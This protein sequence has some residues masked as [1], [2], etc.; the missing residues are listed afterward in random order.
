MQSLHSRVRND[1]PGFGVQWDESAWSQLQGT[2]VHVWTRTSTRT[3][4]SGRRFFYILLYF[5]F[6]LMRRSSHS[7][8]NEC[9]FH[10]NNSNIGCSIRTYVVVVNLKKNVYTVIEQTT[11]H[12]TGQKRGTV[13]ESHHDVTEEGVECFSFTSPTVVVK[14]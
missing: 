4:T 8:M 2:W 3:D 14:K 11:W 13:E 7:R 6:H 10:N 9:S 1:V 12:E 5:F